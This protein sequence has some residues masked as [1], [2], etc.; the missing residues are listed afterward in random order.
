MSELPDSIGGGETPDQRY[1]RC[2]RWY[3]VTVR[4]YNAA[5]DAIEAAEAEVRDAKMWLDEARDEMNRAASVI[6]LPRW[7][8]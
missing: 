5:V 7:E 1:H 8:A 6:G 2:V 3:N 4:R